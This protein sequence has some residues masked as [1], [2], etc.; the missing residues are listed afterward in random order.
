MFG[1]LCSIFHYCCPLE[2]QV[3]NLQH[4]RTGTWF[5]FPNIHLFFT[6][7]FSILVWDSSPWSLSMGDWVRMEMRREWLEFWSEEQLFPSLFF[8]IIVQKL[9]KTK[10]ISITA[11]LWFWTKTLPHL[12]K[13]LHQWSHQYT[14]VQLTNLYSDS[15]N[16]AWLGDF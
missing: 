5:R 11:T 13:D 10:I 3:C 2:V 12:K 9:K 7:Q 16:G 4:S 14:L 6:L 15:Y 8:Y 1:H